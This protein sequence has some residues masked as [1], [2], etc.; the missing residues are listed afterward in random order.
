[1]QNMDFGIATVALVVNDLPRMTDFYSRA[2][3]LTPLETRADIA[4]LGLGATTLIELI[5]DPAARP[6]DP[7]AAGLFHTAFLLPDRKHLGRWLAHADKVGIPLTGAAD[8]LVSEALYLNDPEGNG[9]EIYADRPS[10]TWPWSNGQV[11]MANRRIDLAALVAEHA[12]QEWQGMPPGSSIGH[13]HLQV[14]NLE[15]ADG[16]YARQLGLD[17]VNR[18]P[19]AG[20]Y[21]HGGYHHHLAANNWNSAG[22]GRRMEDHTGLDRIDLTIASTEARKQILAGSQLV[23]SRP[24]TIQD[25]WGNRFRLLGTKN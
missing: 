8:H 12:D 21:S 7:R 17:I 24:D 18:M 1:M 22:A 23:P 25:P 16:F 9:I 10:H 14:G 5:H 3:G 19:Q 20:F 13:V 4:R 6:A 11:L 15:A 2:I